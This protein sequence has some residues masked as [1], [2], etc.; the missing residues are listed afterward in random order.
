MEGRQAESVELYQQALA[1][2][3]GNATNWFNMALAQFQLGEI[4]SA[5]EAVVH[6]VNLDQTNAEY[7]KFHDFLQESLNHP[8]KETS[9]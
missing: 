2:D 4:A 8:K 7:Q 6:A 1:L 3:D 9:R 5:K